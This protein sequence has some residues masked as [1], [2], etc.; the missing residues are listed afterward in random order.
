MFEPL[1]SHQPLAWDQTLHLSWWGLWCSVHPGKSVPW[2]MVATCCHLSPWCLRHKHTSLRFCFHPSSLAHCPPLPG[3]PH[4]TTLDFWMQ[5]L[6]DHMELQS[7]SFALLKIKRGLC[8]CVFHF[9]LF[10]NWG[11]PLRALLHAEPVHPCSFVCMNV[12]SPLYYDAL[13]L[14]VRTLVFDWEDGSLIFVCIEPILV[15]LCARLSLRSRLISPSQC[16]LRIHAD[17]TFWVESMPGALMA[18]TNSQD[19]YGFYKCLIN[20]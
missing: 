16:I 19:I 6:T 18:A 20:A 14:M 10:S 15:Q 4:H 2:S 17:S 3:P 13:M 1:H 9:A 7:I 5:N 12:C 8:L 11:A